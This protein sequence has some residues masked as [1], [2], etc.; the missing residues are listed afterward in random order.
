[1]KIPGGGGGSPTR[2][3]GGGEGPGGCLRGIFGGGAKF[4]FFGAEMPTKA[5]MGSICHFSRALPASICRH[6]SQVLVLLLLAL[7]THKKGRDNDDFSA[8]FPASG[9]LKTSAL[10]PSR[11][12]F[13]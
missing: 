9:Y 5:K 2:G 7:R 8:V 4:F 13:A 12:K 3:A 11:V 10:R 1:M 6:C